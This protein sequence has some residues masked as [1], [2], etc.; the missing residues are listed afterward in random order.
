MLETMIQKHKKKYNNTEVK[1]G[2]SKTR[3]DNC[4]ITFETPYRF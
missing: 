4:H 3:G 1:I 2:A